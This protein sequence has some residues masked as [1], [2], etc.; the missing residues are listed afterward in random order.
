MVKVTKK[1]NTNIICNSDQAKLKLL[2]NV[3]SDKYLAY[4]TNA[5]VVAPITFIEA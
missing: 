1:E 5:A 2:K 3:I 4:E